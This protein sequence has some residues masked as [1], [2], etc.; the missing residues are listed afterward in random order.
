MEVRLNR[1]NPMI[2]RLAAVGLGAFIAVAGGVASPAGA[3]SDL[4][5]YQGT[6][7]ADPE[8][9]VTISIERSKGK[10]LVLFQPQNV[11]RTCDN[12]TVERGT[13]AQVS[14]RLRRDGFFRGIRY[15]N[16]EVYQGF[17]EVKGRILG[18]GRIKGSILQ[19]S[20][21]LENPSPPTLPDCS[22]LGRR[23]WRAEKIG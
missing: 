11:E 4:G 3:G 9:T 12:G 18:G 13:F 22:T 21:S 15:N 1:S 2:G 14:L 10:T 17:Y 20:D 8:A 23:T 6:F 19:L 16:N 7:T 5:H